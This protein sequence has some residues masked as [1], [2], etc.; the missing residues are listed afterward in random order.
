MKTEKLI[1]L[2]YLFNMENK[3][4]LQQN[5]ALHKY[6]E[7]LAEQLNSAGYDMKKVLKPEIDISWTKENVKEY[8][9][10]PI[11]SALFLKKSTTELETKD[12][13]KVYDVLNRH[14]GQK[15]GIE[16]IPFPSEAE[17]IEYDKNY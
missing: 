12:I 14:L 6:F 1:Q 15:L 11:Q 9:W 13:D 4:T 10:K 16:N 3:R 2:I 17:M 5:K 7:L 8:L